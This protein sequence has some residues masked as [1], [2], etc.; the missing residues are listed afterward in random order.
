MLNKKDLMFEDRLHAAKKLCEVMPKDEILAK[1]PLLICSSLESVVLTDIIA[2]EFHLNYEILFTEKIYSPV[3]PETLIAMV[4]ETKDVVVIEA[5]RKSFGI[6]LDYVYGESYR[7]YEEK[8]LKKLY[9]YRKGALINEI[10]EREILLVDEG[11]ETGMTALI[12]I[13]SLLNLGAK[14]ISYATPIIAKFARDNLKAILDEI[15][16]VNTIENFVS[17]DFYYEKK[18]QLPIDE[19]LENS[20]YYLPLQKEGEKDAIQD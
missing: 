17:V 9:K 13:K 14:S 4:S 1:K 7:T 6:T 16:A 8:I 18:L 3:N 2:Q 12:C 20:P 5:L 10:D 19:I 11:C 15:Y